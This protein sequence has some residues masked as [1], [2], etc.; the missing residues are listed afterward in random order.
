VSEVVD[1]AEV[2]RYRALQDAAIAGLPPYPAGA[3]S[4]QGIVILASGAQYFTC[5]WVSINV[6]R[7]VLDCT[8][9][10]EVWYCGPGDMSPQM[11]DL[12]QSLDVRCVDALQACDPRPT[13]YPNG[14]ELKFYA[15]TFS[16]FKDMIYLD[17][18]NV[19]AVDPSSLLSSK[20]YE[21]TGALFWPGGARLRPDNPIWQIC[22][23]PHRD[24]PIPQGGEMVIDKERCWRA[25]QLALYF[26]ERS[27]FY[28]GYTVTEEPIFHLAWRIL[29]QPYVMVPDQLIDVEGTYFQHDLQG[30]VL[31]QHRMVAKWHAWGENK[32]IPG[33][34]HEEE[35]LAF[36]RQLRERW[37]GKVAT[38]VPVA[39]PGPNLEEEII[40]TR[41]FL[42]SRIGSSERILELLP[43]H[44]TGRG[45]DRRALGWYLLQGGAEPAL[46]IEGIREKGCIG[47]I[48]QLSRA[49]NGTWRGHLLEYE[50]MPV[51]LISCAEGG[52]DIPDGM[53]EYT[54]GLEERSIAAARLR[55]GQA[56]NQKGPSDDYLR[57]EPGALAYDRIWGSVRQENEARDE[58]GLSAAVWRM[59]RAYGWDQEIMRARIRSEFRGDGFI[60]AIVDQALS[61]RRMIV[62]P[63]SHSLQE[64][65]VRAA[66][67]PHDLQSRDV[68]RCKGVLQTAGL[69][70]RHYDAA[71]SGLGAILYARP[72]LI[73]DASV[74]ALGAVLA[75]PG[76]P[77]RTYELA[78]FSLQS[79]VFSLQSLP[80]KAATGSTTGVS[81]AQPEDWR[82]AT[83]DFLA[84]L[85]RPD[86]EPE[87][88][89]ALLRGLEDVVCWLPDAIALDRVIALAEQERLADHRDFLLERV[90]ERCAY[91]D[92]AALTLP[93]LERLLALYAEVPAFRY[94]LYY[95]SQAPSVQP[96]VHS[97]ATA[98][99]AGRF[100]LHEAV[101][102]HLANGPKRVLMVQNVADAQ[103]DEIIRTVP[104]LQ[105]L[106]DDNDELEVVLVTNRAY[107][108]A[109][110]R[111]QLVPFGDS[112]ASYLDG[113]WDAVVDFFEARVQDL[114]HDLSL[115]KVLQRRVS[116][117]PVFLRLVAGKG[118]NHYVYKQMSIEFED[119]ASSLGL[120]RQ[121]VPNVYETTKRLISELGLPLRLGEDRSRSESVLA[122][123]PEP[124]VEAEWTELT[125]G[126]TEGRPVALLNP[127]GGSE[128]LKGVVERKLD[129]LADQMRGLIAE[130]FYVILLPNGEPWGSGRIAAD[131]VD[132]LPAA[133]RRYVAIAPDPAGTDRP[134]SVDLPLSLRGAG[135]AM[136]YASYRMHVTMHF[137][138]RADLIVAVEGWMVHAAYCLGK[139]YRIAMMAHSHPF[140]WQPYGTT[141]HQR[142]VAQISEAAPARAP[143]SALQEGSVGPPLEAR[144]RK[145]LFLFILRALGDSPS[146]VE[147]LLRALESEDRDVRLAAAEGLQRYA[148]HSPGDERARAAIL[149]LLQDGWCRVRAVAAATVLEAGEDWPME[150]EPDGR[151]QLR[152]AVLIG[153]EPRR[154]IPVVSLGPAARPALE[155]ALEDDDDVVR[156]EAREVLASI[157]QQTEAGFRS[158]GR[159]TAP[160][161]GFTALA[162]RVP[163]LRGRRREKPAGREPEDKILILTPVKD[164]RVYLPRYRQLLT[165]LT[166]PHRLIS[167]GFLESDSSDDTYGAVKQMLPAL[168]REF[169]RAGIR[170]KD[171]GYQ[172]PEGIHRGAEQI[173]VERRA[174]LGRSRNHLLFH[175]L[176][177]E[178]W[179]LWVDVDLID[180]PP[181]IIESLLATGKDIVQ[182]HCVLQHGGRTFDRN[183]WRDGGR[184]HLDDLRGEGELVRLDAVGGT[185]L[186]VRADVHRDGLIFP[187]FPYGKENEKIRQD[188]G[189]L[190][191]EGL[192]IMARDMGYECW[193]M[194]H[195]EI[196]HSRG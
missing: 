97:A 125:R 156:R 180:Y 194:P 105:A 58:P 22:G 192:G 158:A 1:Q 185:M 63:L 162:G 38:P 42:Y 165:D 127:F 150:W 28:Y 54:S 121:R 56:A 67:R 109:H 159:P 65:V 55:M 82:S 32:R 8:L 196:L 138:R 163:G 161:R 85:S 106:L 84:L 18:D 52:D 70:P 33:F 195:L 177:D 188:R 7:K 9:P 73:N 113:P 168:Q 4:G 57:P 59:L 164:A 40:R 124:A 184:W 175:A 167:I 182:P 134:A 139:R 95:L 135:V 86:L 75:Y 110:P 114:N 71:V 115:E 132:R 116:A 31:F 155:R 108:Y 94:L 160:R 49:A 3:F 10:I 88:H 148:A 26:N 46:V 21:Q 141:R 90:I 76:L 142:A 122:G 34:A 107:L 39:R 72:E 91:A 179:V 13:R 87:A 30:R 6:L 35:C 131:V 157:D 23:I 25:L 80:G 27:E 99:V 173:Q 104:L 48:C 96:G 146:A 51:E 145:D 102:R 12:L 29:G 83:D 16:R 77:G 126:N 103:G 123:I 172:L 174:V 24:E 2:A 183:G 11:I 171:F 187:A 144:P 44:R 170:K 120:A 5:A 92:P 117:R 137:I 136:P 152:A 15:L 89:D 41:R 153:A 64:T 111:V 14:M 78:V 178:D 151:Q 100:P 37:D 53:K 128:P 189:E 74:A 147:P 129:D 62:N 17:A 130:G 119:Y 166:Y 140:N 43:D 20:E 36:L 79:S 47:P 50:K 154:W 112:A 81:T 118:N 93:Q 149:D 143:I 19:M 191:T 169:R 45:R 68:A 98:F 181:D 176:D 186:L 61:G 60:M 66:V 193:G 133:E 190:E 69:Q 101:A